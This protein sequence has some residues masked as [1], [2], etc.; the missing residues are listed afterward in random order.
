MLFAD[1]LVIDPAFPR[2]LWPDEGDRPNAEDRNAPSA[3]IL[4]WRD[5]GED[6]E[7]R[8]GRMKTYAVSELGFPMTARPK[9]GRLDAPLI[10][11]STRRYT[12]GFELYQENAGGCR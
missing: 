8:R 2:S 12:L 1:S 5:D 7:T 11:S 9:S 3:C 10:G 4:V 6:S